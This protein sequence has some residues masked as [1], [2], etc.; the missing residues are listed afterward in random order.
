VGNVDM[1][2]FSYVMNAF[3]FFVVVIIAGSAGVFPSSRFP[4]AY[5]GT[6]ES[7]FSFL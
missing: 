1:L 5:F 3:P 7:L 6:F 2:A 4:P